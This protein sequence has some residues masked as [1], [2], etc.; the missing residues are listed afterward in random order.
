MKTNFKITV[1]AT[2]FLNLVIQ[3]GNAQP[4]M[5]W[6]KQFNGV[7]SMSDKA[8]ATAID[9][10]CN[11]YVTG[12]SDKLGAGLNYVTIKYDNMGDVVWT[13]EY[14]GPDHLD[15]IP[16]A[17]K[18][19]ANGNVYVT[20]KSASASGGFDFLTVKY[21]SSG[22]QQWASRLNSI[23]NSDDVANDLAV[24]ANGN[25]Y[26]CG[27]QGDGS[28]MVKYYSS[29]SQSWVHTNSPSGDYRYRYYKILISNSGVIEVLGDEFDTNNGFGGT[30]NE[31]RIYKY[32]ASGYTSMLRWV[33]GF[34]PFNPVPIDFVHN[35]TGGSFISTYC[36]ES[37]NENIYVLSTS[38]MN[39]VFAIYNPSGTGNSRVS[40]IRLDNSGNVYLSGYTDINPNSAINYDYIVLKF[41]SSGVQQWMKTFG[42]TGED[43]ALDMALGSG[44]TP[45][46]YV[47]GYVTNTQGDKDIKTIKYNNNGTLQTAWTQTY[48]GGANNDAVPVELKTDAYNN[49]I[50]AGYSGQLN[51]EDYTTIKYISN[52]FTPVITWA[53]P[54]TYTATAGTDY[55]WYHNNAPVNGANQQSLNISATGSGDYYCM[56]SQYCYTYKSNIATN[57]TVG[58]NQYPDSDS[59]SIYPNPNQGVFT[60]TY[61][62]KPNCSGSIEVFNMTGSC[63]L[64]RVLPPGSSEQRINLP[65]IGDGLY[66][67]VITSDNYR[68]S[69][70]IM[71][72]NNKVL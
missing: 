41:N 16:T 42:G 45:D 35:S 25:V 43:K 10:S 46:I 68:A 51:A 2:I 49:V 9:N 71:V 32:T 36:L 26:V 4:A 29:G 31:I 59:F 14:D 67:C 33:L 5:T 30:E 17:I 18:V 39:S 58:L 62:L 1:I 7:N 65:E 23:S 54:N 8:T 47:T 57:A 69:R 50:L 21:N 64:K 40:R 66:I 44:S 6:V 55:Q 60:V 27:N 37:G 53:A 70:K 38:N 56:V 48:D 72:F 19:D 20:G 63:I 3:Y 15:D 22:S 13:A 34:G 11:V 28:A 24:D 52:T 61:Q 12:Q